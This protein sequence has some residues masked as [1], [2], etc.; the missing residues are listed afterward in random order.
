MIF[1]TRIPSIRINDWSSFAALTLAYAVCAQAL[2]MLSNAD[3]DNTLFWMPNGIAL[4]LLLLKQSRVWFGI[5]A[6]SLISGLIQHLPWSATAVMAC[7]NTLEVYASVRLLNLYGNF[8]SHLQRTGDFI[9]LLAVAVI[10]AW[11]SALLG[12]F[13]AWH[14]R[15][16]DSAALADNVF[17]WWRA[18]ILGM[19]IGTPCLLVWRRWPRGWFSLAGR[20]LEAHSYILLSLIVPATL[21]M[22]FLSEFFGGVSP[23]YWMFP[24]LLWGA[25]RFG[26]HGVLLLLLTVCIVGY[27]GM[28]SGAGYFAK[29][30]YS[31]GQNLWLYLLILAIVGNLMALMLNARRQTEEALRLKTQELD[32][33]FNNALDLFSIAD[34]RGY[35]RKLNGR[36][37][38]LLGYGL[39]ELT[40]KPFLELVHPDDIEST[41]AAM[42][43]LAGAATVN[44]FVNRYRHSDGSW[45]WIEWNSCAQGDLIYSAARDITEQKAAEDELRLA[46][47]VYQNSSESM[48]ITDENNCIISVNRAFTACTG[49]TPEEVLGKNP[50][51]LNSGRQPA[52]FYKTMWHALNTSGRWQGEIHNKRKNAEIYAEWVV[53]NTVFNAD[54]KVHR[55][56]ALFSDISEK[57]KSD[58]LIWFHAN[59]DPLTQLPNRRLFIDRLQQDLIKARRDQQSL[60]LLFIDLDHF[61]EVNDGLGHST[62]DELL[63]QVAGRLTACVRKSDTVARLGGDEFTIIISEL[64]DNAYLEKISQNILLALSQPFTLGTSQA[65]VSASIGITLSPADAE[66]YEDLIRFADQAMYAA[67]NKGRNM[68]CFFTPA[69]QQKVETHMHIAQDL[70]QALEDEQF[71]V[72]YQPIVDLARR[73]KVVK[74]EALIRWLHPSRGMIMPLDFISVAEETGIIN[75]IGDWIFKQAAQQTRRWQQD[76]LTDFQI[77]VNKSPVQF[78]SQDGLHRHW[79]DYLRG[80]HMPADSVV[81]EITE[82]LLL[83]DSHN[84]AK[85]LLHFKECGIQVAI[86]DFGT[87]YSALSY[88]KKFHIEFLKIDQ[89]FTRNLAPGSSDLALCEAIIV[90]AHKLGIKVI[91]EGIETRQQRDFLAQAGCDYGQGYL[92]A[93]PMPAGDFEQLLKAQQYTADTDE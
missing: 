50:R 75:D 30:R 22:D 57:K 82:G 93:K 68:Y 83:D 13:V 18:N 91:A 11:V 17:H 39:G 44:N 42:T 29:Y 89:S 60:G 49:Y 63:K 43:R 70:H 76:Y 67:K 80:L 73:D 41:K 21:F 52:A 34:T 47:L 81:I 69:M 37:E 56:V 28:K 79:T 55:R 35:F 53:I 59:Y 48:M 40:D 32:A 88:L 38:E 27:I 72:Y 62:G 7:A 61:K 10:S 92:F 77:G 23:E 2:T 5:I 14:L 9:V 54:G 6:G 65:Y 15:L 74:A 45:R 84:T 78:H 20:G 19:V 8:D 71:I 16:L 85:K 58:E 24:L 36:W 4:A 1:L 87:G 26:H 66:H 31:D 51:I 46:A 86:D 90:M 33:Y 64:N 25:F 12:S 3:Q